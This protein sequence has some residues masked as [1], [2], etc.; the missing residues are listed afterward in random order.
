MTLGKKITELRT[1]HHFSQGDLAEKMNVSRQSVSKWE[2]DTSIPDLDKL[3]LM[4]EL[5]GVSLDE[6][7]KDKAPEGPAPAVEDRPGPPPNPGNTQRIIGFLLLAVGLF[8]AVLGL[9]FGPGL[10]LVALYPIACGAICLA[11]KC[12][13]GLIIGWGSWILVVWFLPWATRMNLFSIFSPFVYQEGWWIDLVISGALWALLI[14]LTIATA[15][16]TRI[17]NRAFLFVG[18]G[19]FFINSRRIPMAFGLVECYSKVAFFLAWATVLLWAVL[20]F[21]TAKALLRWW[22]RRRTGQ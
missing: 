4:S 1:E 16:E 11:V 2:T 10:I 12:H 19:L 6:L 9:L 13:A 15:R 20:I 18:W 5:F 7:V 3:V 21:F 17:R 22:K 14:W 8:A